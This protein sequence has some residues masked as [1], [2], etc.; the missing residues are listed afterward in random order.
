VHLESLSYAKHRLCAAIAK[1]LSDEEIAAALNW[2]ADAARTTVQRVLQQLGLS[3]V[4]FALEYTALNFGSALLPLTAVFDELPYVD[5]PTYQS[6]EY[7]TAYAAFTVL[8]VH[9]SHLQHTR[10]EAIA[11]LETSALPLRTIRF[12]YLKTLLGLEVISQYLLQYYQLMGQGCAYQEI[13]NRLNITRNEVMTRY[14]SGLAAAGLNA[15]NAVFDYTARFP[16]TP[17]ECSEANKLL[18]ELTPKQQRTVL[19]FTEY[20]QKNRRN[21]QASETAQNYVARKL[22]V[23]S[24]V[25]VSQTLTRAGERINRNAENGR[26]LLRLQLVAN[27]S[28]ST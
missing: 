20:W 1:G 7:R 17:H 26:G 9:N 19:F 12:I 10:R 3:R 21:A 2:Q 14:R 24:H 25:T 27:Y 11:K 23:T 13:A 28:A 4:E 15:I 8:R 5:E 22:G 6:S 16:P 18:A